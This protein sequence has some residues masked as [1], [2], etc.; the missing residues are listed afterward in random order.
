MRTIKLRVWNSPQDDIQVVG[1]NK[2]PTILMVF[3]PKSLTAGARYYDIQVVGNYKNP[4][5]L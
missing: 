2:N 4:T 1:N 3:T 5:I